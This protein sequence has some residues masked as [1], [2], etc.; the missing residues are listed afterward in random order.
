MIK[1]SFL[2][3]IALILCLPCTVQAKVEHLLPKPQEVVVTPGVAFALSG[4]VSINYADGVAQ[5]EL[6]DKVPYKGGI[7]KRRTSGQRRRH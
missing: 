1:K 4:A 7:C 3:L 6:L 5:C 2:A